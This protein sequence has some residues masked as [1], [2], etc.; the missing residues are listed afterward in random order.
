LSKKAH[1][2]WAWTAW[3]SNHREEDDMQH[4]DVFKL[5]RPGSI[6]REVQDGLIRRFGDG[7]PFR[8]KDV[9]DE[10]RRAWK[11][12]KGKGKREC[13]FE[14]TLAV[15]ECIRVTPF[16]IK[17]LKPKWIEGH[18]QHAWMSVVPLREKLNCDRRRDE[19]HDLRDERYYC[20]LCRRYHREPVKSPPLGKYNT[21]P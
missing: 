5:A 11:M 19:Y 15:S 20:V 21:M 16:I 9:R 7:Q 8:W 14:P 6:R 18:P 17:H 13:P 2:Q 1:A 10:Y 4:R 3:V 12:I